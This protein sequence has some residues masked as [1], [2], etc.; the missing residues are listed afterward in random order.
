MM[1][2]KMHGTGND[3]VVVDARSEPVADAPGLSRRICDRHAGVGADGLIL[4][5]RSETAVV[6]MEIYNTDGSRPQMC[7][8]G[9]RCVAKYAFEHGLCSEASILIDTDDGVKMAECGVDDGRVTRVRI[10]MGRPRFAPA[11]IPVLLPGAAVVNHPVEVRGR[12]LPMTCVS[13]GNPHA[14]L[15]VDDFDSIQLTVDGAA[16]E[17]HP[18]FPERVNVHFVRVDDASRVTVH[19]WERGSGATRA[20]GTGASAV[21]VAGVRTER[22]RRRITA[23]VPGGELDLEW[24]QAGPVFMTGPAVEVF[25]GRWSGG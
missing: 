21:C 16:L 7:G 19:T 22:T 25:Q 18:L 11:E 12:S 1:F 17:R 15:F 23:C 8:N 9:I 3:F 14:V 4:L 6:R 13:M 5:R 24:T 2:S 20:C 10:D